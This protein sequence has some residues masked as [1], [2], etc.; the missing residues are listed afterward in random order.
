[1][2]DNLIPIYSFDDEETGNGWNIGTKVLSIVLI[3]AM[4]MLFGVMP[5]FW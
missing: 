4:T 2:E 1:M 5:Y 3:F